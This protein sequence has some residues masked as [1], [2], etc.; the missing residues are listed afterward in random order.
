MT[1]RTSPMQVGILRSST[2][3]WVVRRQGSGSA[4]AGPISRVGWRWRPR[5]RHRPILVERFAY[6]QGF[7]RRHQEL[8]QDLGHLLQ[9]RALDLELTLADKCLPLLQLVL[10][11]EKCLRKGQWRLTGKGRLPPQKR[12]LERLAQNLPLK[13]ELPSE[14]PQVVEIFHA[15]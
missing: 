3:A 15:T 1:R 9:I 5:P 4:A 2:R 11:P 7:N 6:R 12:C 14:N 13:R 8:P 10:V